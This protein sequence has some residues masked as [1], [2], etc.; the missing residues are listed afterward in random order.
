MNDVFNLIRYHELTMNKEGA[1]R[2]LENDVNVRNDILLK[3]DI[4]KCFGQSYRNK[5][6]K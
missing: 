4:F 1:G 3:R 5:K 2:R 6:K